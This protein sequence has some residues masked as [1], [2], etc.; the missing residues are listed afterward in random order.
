MIAFI[1]LYVKCDY[2]FF[3]QGINKIQNARRLC[4]YMYIYVS[5]L[6]TRAFLSLEPDLFKQNRACGLSVCS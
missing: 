2:G 3:L 1:I 6:W 5:N 4:L